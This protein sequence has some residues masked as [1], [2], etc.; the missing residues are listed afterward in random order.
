[1]PP[2][3]RTASSTAPIAI[4]PV[5]PA[6]LPWPPLAPDT[7]ANTAD[8]ADR[9]EMAVSDRWDRPLRDVRISVT[10]RC[11]FRCGY[12][13]PREVFDKHHAF[14]PQP[15]L[16]SFEEITRAA[17][18]LLQLGVRKIRLTGGEPLLRRGVDELVGMLAALRTREGTPPDL[19]MTTNGVLLPRMAQRLRAAGL[20]RITVSLDAL[21]ETTFQRM[22]D[23]EHTVQHVLDGIAAAQAA[24]LG[25]IK[26]NMV[27][28]KGVNDDQILPM[29]AHFRGSG[30]ALR[31]IEYMDVGQ[32][33]RW[34]MDEVLPSEAVRA[35]IASAHPLVPVTDAV[36]SD[37]AQR[38]RYAD[39]GGE[40]G[41]ISSV[42]RAFCGDCTR[43]R[44]STEGRLYTCLFATAGRDLR[45]LL[46]DDAID[47]AQIAAHV[48]ALW[49]QRDD[50]YS[51][52]R[53]EATGSPLPTHAAGPRVEMSYIGG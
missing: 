50:R 45:Q 11:N 49:A 28:R 4:R 18:V 27:V 21:D 53:G 33:N 47:D 41:F 9:S 39:G 52:L 12:C 8:L 13:M 46:R 42:T 32:T 10:D 26:V 40:V 48:Q 5:G 16:L 24:G 2:S 44:L 29:A 1:M 30:I 19:A 14:L 51:A 43:L 17:R 22:A 37:T 38:W 36:A 7:P 15:A 31:F 34:C 3:R 23:T 6:M 25:P 35:R 20:Q